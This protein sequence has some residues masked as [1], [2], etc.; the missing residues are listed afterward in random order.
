MISSRECYFFFHKS[1]SKTEGVSAS[2]F[3]IQKTKQESC[4]EKMGLGIRTPILS[5]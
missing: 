1:I 3:K 2:F 4:V 5:P